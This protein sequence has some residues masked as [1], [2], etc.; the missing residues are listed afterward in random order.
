V[1]GGGSIVL[2]GVIGVVG[3]VGEPMI[4]FS[5]TKTLFLRKVRSISGS[6]A[7]GDSL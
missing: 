5:R 4:L 2:L 3:V 1:G 6:N 7:N